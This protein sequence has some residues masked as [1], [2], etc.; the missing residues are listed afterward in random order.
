LFIFNRQPNLDK[1]IILSPNIGLGVT[2]TEFHNFGESVFLQ[3]VIRKRERDM[4][5]DGKNIKL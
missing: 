3:G 5:D 2:L 1:G 4:K